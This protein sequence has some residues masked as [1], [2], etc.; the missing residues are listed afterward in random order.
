[1]WEWLLRLAIVL[2]TLDVGVR[3][4]QLDREEILKG[5][6]FARRKL[7][8]WEAKPRPVQADESLAALLHRRD[9]VRSVRPQ[10]AAEPN[11]DL[12]RPKAAG[13]LPRDDTSG[14]ETPASTEPVPDAAQPD[15]KP[16][17]TTSRLLEAKRRAQRKTGSE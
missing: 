7:L 6:A 15:Q 1:L 2:F 11:P 14:K 13:A 17:A 4:I 10:P 12:F 5:L 8:F 16:V 9:Q 3:R